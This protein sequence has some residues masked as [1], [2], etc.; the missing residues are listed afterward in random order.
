MSVTRRWR[1]L[2]VVALACTLS[3]AARAVELR[4]DLSILGQV[5]DGD[6][7]NQ[8]ET[9]TNLYGEMGA[10]RVYKGIGAE[11]YFRLERDFAQGTGTTDFYSGS[12]HI[13]LQGVDVSLGRQVINEV[14]GGFF[15]AD[16]GRIRIN[17]G[18]PF[19]LTIFG[20]QPQYFEPT[21][22]SPSLSQDEQI[23]GG[24]IRTTQLKNGS[25]SF[26]FLQQ[27]RD[28]NTLRQLISTT[29]SQS[30]PQ[31]PGLPNL[32]GSAAYDA[33]RQNIYLGTIGVDTFLPMPR[34]SLNVEG[35]YYK[36]HDDGSR[37]YTDINRLQDPLFS[38][39]S[40]SSMK[41]AR[42]A[43]RYAVTR[44][45]SVYGEYSY[46]RYEQLPGNNLNGHVGSG[47]VV[48]LPGGDGLEL[49]R[50]EYYAANSGGGTVNGVRAAYENRVYDRIV[51]RTKLDVSYYEKASNQNDTAVSGRIGVAYVLAKGL[52]AE[53]SFEGNANARFKDD[54]RFG[55]Y[56]TYNLRY[57][58][59]RLQGAD[60]TAHRLPGGWA[61]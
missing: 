31:L 49:V 40:M 41:Q 14:P 2:A 33:T 57:R 30:F 8:T 13:P 26:G 9:P 22:S 61:G 6:Q 18:G 48:W 11:S 7:S 3:G 29:L 50:G 42:S 55:F 56:L 54:L 16:A 27:Q 34:L 46:Q 37:Y 45:F 20:G 28:G 21:Y 39:F 35:G 58:D 12:V 1:L 53:V 17:T 15:V 24:S 51:F 23:F 32:Y 5:R 59:D 36:P 47:G 38:M 25:V 4:S 19:M 60:P 52:L 44:S 43:L 10:E